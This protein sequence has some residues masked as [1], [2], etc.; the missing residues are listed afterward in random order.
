MNILLTG[1]AGFIGFHTS[2][3]LLEK[4]NK[5]FGVDNLNNYYD[6]KLKQSRLNKLKNDKN[7][8]FINSDIQKKNLKLKI[9]KKHEQS[10]INCIINLAAQA[11]VRHSLVDP[12][13]YIDS[14][15]WG[16]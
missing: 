6:I 12:Y 8:F 4:G 3:L 1:V 2:K 10:K 9:K 11:G 15:V 7:F 5:V 13:S 14:N 16:N